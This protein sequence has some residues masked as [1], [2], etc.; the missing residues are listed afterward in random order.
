MQSISES[1][2]VFTGAKMRVERKEVLRPVPRTGTV[3]NLSS[4]PA[5]AR[6][7]KTNP[8]Y[9]SPYAL[10]PS[11]VATTGDIQMASN[12]MFWI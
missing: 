9:P 12:P 7:E 3:S 8:W 5:A 11:K 4:S 6:D 10:D 1:L 2:Q